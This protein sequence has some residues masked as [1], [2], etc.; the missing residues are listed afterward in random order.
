M[1]ERFF[2]LAM[3]YGARLLF[4]VAA[5]IVLMGIFDGVQSVMPRGRAVPETRLSYVTAFLEGLSVG[6]PQFVFSIMQALPSATFPL[7]GALVIHR[8]DRW[9]AERKL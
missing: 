6:W 3:K 1:F 9:L 2:Q 7:F 4:A 8:I 5:L